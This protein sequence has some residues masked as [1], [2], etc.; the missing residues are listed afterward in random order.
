[1]IIGLTG[2]I[3]SGKSAAA[4]C[5][6]ELGID[7]IDADIIAKNTLSK[8]SHGYNLF[9]QKF[10][11]GLLDKNKEINRTLLRKEIFSNEIKKKELENIIHP[12]MR[13]KISDF[14]NNSESPY[15]I[16]M[17]PLIFETNSSDNYDRI[18][19]ID[20]DVKTQIKRSSIRDNQSNKDIQ[21]IISS[22]AT[23]DERLSIAD[24]VVLNTS[25]FE[26]LKNEIFKI[27]KKYMEIINNA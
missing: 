18:L 27:H 15:C 25:S 6:I 1:M 12:N 8:D 13:S 24:D 7:V 9:V 11:E 23:R 5:F 4:D 10:G 3:G 17:V 20:C 22:Q 26:Y 19:L 14:I 21:K 16:V 2:G